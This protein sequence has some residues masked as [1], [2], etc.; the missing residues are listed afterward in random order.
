MEGD[1]TLLHSIRVETLV[2]EDATAQV[3]DLLQDVSSSE[4][5]A[6]NE[7][8]AVRR[9]DLLFI[10]ITATLLFLELLLMY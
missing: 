7:I 8:A 6:A 3:S 4:T 1:Q 5:A 2:P 9:R 10:G